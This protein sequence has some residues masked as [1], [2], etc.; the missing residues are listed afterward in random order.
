LSKTDLAKSCWQEKNT[1]LIHE[2]FDSLDDVDKVV[3]DI[4]KSIDII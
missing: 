2:E 4:T 3:A 1:N